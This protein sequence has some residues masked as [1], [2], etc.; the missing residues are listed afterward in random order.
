[1]DLTAIP[2]KVYF[3]DEALEE[4]LALLYVPSHEHLFTHRPEILDK[5]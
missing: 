1:M 5:L 3:F 2:R 4:G